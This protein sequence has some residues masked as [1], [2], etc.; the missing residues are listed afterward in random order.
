MTL[1]PAGAKVYLAFGYTDV[2]KGIDGSPGWSKACCSRIRGALQCC[3]IGD[4]IINMASRFNHRGY[5]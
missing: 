2:R 1:L 5:Q 4:Q 3:R